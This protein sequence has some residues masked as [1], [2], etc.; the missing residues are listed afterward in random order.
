VVGYEV[1]GKSKERLRVISG[2]YYLEATTHVIL[3]IVTRLLARDLRSED[4]AVTSG[5]SMLKYLFCV[6]ELEAARPRPSFV[7]F[8]WQGCIYTLSTL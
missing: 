6:S 4:D 8:Y 3:S 5:S 7:V 2:L 1:G